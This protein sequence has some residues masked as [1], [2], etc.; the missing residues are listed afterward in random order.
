MFDRRSYK[1]CG[2]KILKISIRISSL[3]SIVWGLI[4]IGVC[5][6]ALAQPYRQQTQRCSTRLENA[7]EHMRRRSFQ[8]KTNRS[9][10]PTA[11]TP[12]SLYH[13]LYSDQRQDNENFH[14]SRNESQYSTDN[15]RPNNHFDLINAYPMSSNHAQY[16]STTNLID[17][18]VPH[19]L[20]IKHVD[21]EDLKVRLPSMAASNA[22]THWVQVEKC[23]FSSRNSTLD[24]RLIFPDLML[25]GKVILQ[26]SGGNCNMI[27]RLRHA[28]IEF[29]TVPIGYEKIGADEE[30]RRLNGA[31]VRT[32]SHFTEPGFI[33]VFAHGCQGPTGI[34]LRRNSRRHFILN[35]DEL[36]TSL[37]LQGAL[38]YD[39][40]T[41]R[42]MPSFI[43]DLNGSDHL[44]KRTINFKE[45]Y[46]FDENDSQHRRVRQKEVVESPLSHKDKINFNDD[47]LNVSD[48]KLQDMMQPD[49]RAFA[50]ELL[51]RQDVTN[52]MMNDAL[53]NELEKLFSLGVR[54]LLTTYM[55]KALQ[56]AIKETLME[57][58]GYKLSYG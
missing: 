12:Y 2:I 48:D 19:K 25:S 36:S 26:P 58:M 21:V 44:T 1:K 7:L 38:Y 31:S 39:I 9:Y 46:N 33:S 37:P 24:T 42:Y 28:G 32:D 13:E 5:R 3:D 30:T 6:D 47:V 45:F 56:P 57:N 29:R 14:S 54:G 22:A 17:R 20:I 15:Q 50:A 35:E 27:L 23:K 53:S 40:R 52:N 18:R 55:Q 49:A 41:G 10:E 11:Q 34:K 4:I 8:K 16:H 43:D 51:S